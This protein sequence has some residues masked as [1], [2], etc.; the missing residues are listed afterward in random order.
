[1]EDRGG[2]ARVFSILNPRSSILYSPSGASKEQRGSTRQ[3]DF[4]GQ[5]GIEIGISILNVISPDLLE[6]ALILY[7]MA[8]LDL[9]PASPS[10]DGLRRTGSELSCGMRRIDGQVSFP[11]QP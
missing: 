11:R 3:A 10:E 7:E 8:L 6:K 1:M 2:R 5:E 9:S 4:L